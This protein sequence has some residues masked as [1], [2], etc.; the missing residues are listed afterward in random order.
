MRTM[1]LRRMEMPRNKTCLLHHHQSSSLLADFVPETIFIIAGKHATI[2][3]AAAA[4]RRSIVT[5]RVALGTFLVL[6]AVFLCIGAGA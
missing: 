3:I 5:A 4:V 2:V 1:Y 6:A